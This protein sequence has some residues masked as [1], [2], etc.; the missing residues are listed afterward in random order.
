M[1]KLNACG[2]P[3]LKGFREY[4]EKERFSKSSIKTYTFQAEKFIEWTE[5]SGHG[6][7]DFDYKKAVNYVAYL[8]KRHANIR[9]INGKIA[10]TRQY[11]NF[12]VEKCEASEN[13]FAEILVKGDKAKK[14]LQNIL[15]ADELEDLYYS[16]ETENRTDKRT[17]SILAGKRNKVMLGLMVYQGLSTTDMKRLRPE[18]VEP[19]KGKVYIPS[20]KIGG[21]REL[22]LMPWQVME[23][24]E[25]LNDTWPQLARRKNTDGELFPVTNGRLTDTVAH[26]IKKLRK[27]NRKVRNGH[28]IRA[29]VIVNWLEKHSLRKVQVMAGHRRISTTERYVQEDLKQLQQIINTFHP[30]R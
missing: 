18:H 1:S 9:T 12:L 24:V 30:L 2:G 16:Y 8:Q 3:P 27:V 20:G 29:S 7:I 21:R 13:P 6:F 23:L 19:Q 26:I 4:L 10:A 5:S 28:Q 11:F 25:Y 22:A 17:S 15:S 14:M